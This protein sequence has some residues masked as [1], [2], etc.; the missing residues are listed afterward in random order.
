MARP[1]RGDFWSKV[2]RSGGDD[3]CWVW[4]R[5]RVPT[6]Y[7]QYRAGPSGPMLAH[8]VAWALRFGHP[9]RE[10]DVCHRC[11]NRLCVNP[12][13]LFLGTR[14]DNMQDAKM[15]GRLKRAA[16]TECF[17]G[18]PMSG[19]NLYLYPSG[20]RACRECRR[21]WKRARMAA[22]RGA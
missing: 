16:P 3:S 6:G 21:I 17:R 5:S 14:R 13:H 20:N 1:E 15:K 4:M 19:D 10:M 9:P 11:D 18:H 7:G 12:Q 22:A 8:R 2:N